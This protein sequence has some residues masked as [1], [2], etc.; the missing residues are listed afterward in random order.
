[1]LAK[2][3]R[4]A[5]VAGLGA[6]V[7]LVAVAACDGE[8]PPVS[9]RVVEVPGPE[10][11]VEVEVPGPE[12]VVEVE[13]PGP[14]RIVEVEVPA[15]ADEKPELTLP[16]DLVRYGVPGEITHLDPILPSE[17][18]IGM[19]IKLIS[20]QL[21]RFDKG[22]VPQL[23]LAESVDISEDGLTYTFRLR[24][25]L[26]YSDGTPLTAEDVIYTWER[27]KDAPPIAKGPISTVVGWDAPDDRTAVWTLSAPSHGLLGW[28]AR[29]SFAIHP[30]DRVEADADAYFRN[31]VSAGPYVITDGEP[32]DPVLV[33]Q[34]NPDY[35]LGPMS[36][37]T[38]EMHWVPDATSR[39]LLLASGELDQVYEVAPPAKDAFPPEVETYV[40]PHGG[41]FHLS[42]NMTLPETHCLSDRNVREAISLAWDR[43]EINERALFG[44]SPPVKGYYYTGA[45]KA[46]DGTDIDV[47]I[48]PDG[49]KQ[50]LAAAKA[51][52]AETPWADGGCSFAVTTYAP[53]THY[54][55][56]IIVFAEQL[57]EL[58]MDVTP[59]PQ[60][61]GAALDFMANSPDYEAGFAVTGN[62]A[63]TPEQY[64]VHQYY[65]GFW[66]QRARL[67][68]PVLNAMFE[69]MQT[70]PSQAKRD[71]LMKDIQ[72][73]GY[74]IQS[75]IPCCERS[76]MGATRL[77]QFGSPTTGGIISHV[78]GA[79][80]IVLAPMSD[81]Q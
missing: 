45:P 58:N 79:S 53:R 47:G 81:F 77:G 60:D 10:R 61:I 73:R 22:G 25:G 4:T 33:L 21:V 54:T 72:Y 30:K 66:A 16:L 65:H 64:L 41:V 71:Q 43:G 57:K 67:D 15:M 8:A 7:L 29:Y 80:S 39:A 55:D 27:I 74:E 18:S 12:R 48:L 13:V 26:Q 2:L 75:I 49:G 52:M 6:L 35:P 5:A 28:F 19:T 17:T 24:D 51:L 3:N 76:G 9:E 11:I 70:E 59:D 37:K 62:N 68:D 42:I 56:A 31:P 69:E 78:K 1:M 32:G 63:G 20:G 14:E 44:V 40:A 23:D 50:N 36:V 34:E 46:Q 38:L